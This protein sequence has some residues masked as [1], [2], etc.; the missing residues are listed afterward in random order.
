MSYKLNEFNKLSLMGMTITSGTNSARFQEGINPRD[1]DEIQQ[2]RT[3]RYQTR[4]LNTFQMRGEHYLPANEISLNWTVSRSE[5]QMQTPDLR[6]FFNNYVDNEVVLTD[7]AVFYDEDGT[8]YD[9]QTT[10]AILGEID[11]L[12]SDGV[13]TSD[14]ANDI[15]GTLATLDDEGIEFPVGNLSVP[16]ETER[17]YTIQPSRYPAPP[18]TGGASTRTRPTSSSTPPSPS[19]ASLPHGKASSARV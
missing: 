19:S 9:A 14:W 15:D 11:D 1:G 18:A 17:F 7:Q 2:Q 4:N 8:A 6:T 3:H 5:G 10:E 12:V 13:L 16:T